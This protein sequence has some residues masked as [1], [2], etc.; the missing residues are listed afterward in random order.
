MTKSKTKE[1]NVNEN[2]EVN[3]DELIMNAGTEKY[4][5]LVLA[6]KWVYHLKNTE[7]YKDKT[8]AEIIEKALKDVLTGSVKPDEI[9]KAMEKDEEI[10]LEKIAE[11]KREKAAKK[12]ANDK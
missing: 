9:A 2:T 4:T 11:R 12:A 3:L 7:E 1:K 8:T 6:M 10:R 5:S